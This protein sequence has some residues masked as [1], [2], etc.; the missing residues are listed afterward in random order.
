MKVGDIINGHVNEDENFI[1]KRLKICKACPLFKK[2]AVGGICNPN[3]YINETDKQ[4]VSDRPK[5]G[6]KR[7]C[8]CLLSRKCKVPNAK[9]IVGKW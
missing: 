1:E 5:L 2:G 6:Y 9:C 8:G 4:T 7:G 3:L